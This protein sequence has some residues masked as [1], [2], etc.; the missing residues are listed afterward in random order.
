MSGVYAGG[1]GLRGTQQWEVKSE[2]TGLDRVG[3]RRSG[4]FCP[5][6][7]VGRS[8]RLALGAVWGWGVEGETHGHMTRCRC[9][10]APQLPVESR[11]AAGHCPGQS[12]V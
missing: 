11:E 9:S 8:H 3:P 4:G 12:C 1:D 2:V 10:Q 6:L 7:C 5:S